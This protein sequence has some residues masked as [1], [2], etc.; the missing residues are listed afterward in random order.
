MEI[1]FSQQL[2]SDLADAVKTALITHGIVNIPQ[3]AETI[4]KRHEAENIALEDITALVMA[5]AQ[6]FSA[7]M[8]F[9]HPSLN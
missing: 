4:R 3:L 1:R 5:Q 8:E 7:V 6:K 9:D 2:I